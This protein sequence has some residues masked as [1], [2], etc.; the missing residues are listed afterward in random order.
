MNVLL[1]G[2]SNVGKTTTGRLLAKK[3]AYDFYDIDEEVKNR[4]NT[5]IEKFIN[6]FGRYERDKVRGGIIGQLLDRNG[7]KVISVSPIY[8]SR[9]FN[10]YIFKPDVIAI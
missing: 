10:K 8:Y 2:V 7:D 4:F 5:T 3:L 6:A 9:W 1:F